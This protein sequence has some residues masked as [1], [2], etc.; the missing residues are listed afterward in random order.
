MLTA[1]SMIIL[2]RISFEKAFRQF[3]FLAI[4]CVGMLIIPLFLQKGSLF[5]RFS[6]VY[7]VVGVALLAYVVVMGS[8]SYGAKLNITI[9]GIAF[10]PSEF[11]KIIFVFF[12]A[13]MLYKDNSTKRIFL[14]SCLS[15]V[16]ILL[17]THTRI[18]AY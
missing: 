5:R 1:I 16:F 10:Q 18:V 8:I 17:K 11:V 15:A 9:A 2:T 3:I 13:G 4:G 7:F 6:A 12:I 14:T